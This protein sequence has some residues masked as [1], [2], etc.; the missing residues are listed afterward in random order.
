MDIVQ[1]KQDLLEDIA[2]QPA[3]VVFARIAICDE[4]QL[5]D[6]MKIEFIPYFRGTAKS[7]SGSSSGDT[8]DSLHRVC[9][10][11]AKQRALLQGS[12]I[13]EVMQFNIQDTSGTSAHSSSGDLSF[14]KLQDASYSS[15]TTFGYTV[16]HDLN[17]DGGV[18]LFLLLQMQI[19]QSQMMKVRM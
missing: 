8:A 7:V 2:R 15:K 6:L 16:M 18:V 14:P 19:L 4:I 3:N 5:A 9:V 1:K 17:E 10:N 12:A 13:N 11:L